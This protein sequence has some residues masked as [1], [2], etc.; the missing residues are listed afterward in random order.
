MKN[1]LLFLA[2][3]LL[4]LPAL[5]LAQCTTDPDE[6]G[7]F[8]TEDCNECVNCLTATPYIQYTAYVV[9]LN[10]TD[11]SG[12][13]GYEFELVNADG[14][15]FPQPGIVITDWHFPSGYINVLLTPEILVGLPTPIPWSSCITLLS[16]EFL[17]LSPAPWCFG[18]KPLE[19]IPTLP[20][21]MVYYR[22]DDIGVPVIMHPI[23]G[24]DAP[25]Y[26]M[27]CF[28]GLECPPPVANDRTT[29]DG[30]K[31]LYR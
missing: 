3:V 26:G 4:F 13:S 12:V 2:L 27:A 8:W 21:Q 1:S 15:Y 17:A 24:P 23:T 20:G 29:W 30:L 9:L 19:I 18:M 10:A 25:D 14:S 6:V 7:I 31:S 5:A 16:F 22:G 11:L 28:N